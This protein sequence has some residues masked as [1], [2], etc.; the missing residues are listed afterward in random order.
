L[1]L[2]VPLLLHWLLLHR[3]L[4]HSALRRWRTTHGLLLHRRRRLVESETGL[5][6]PS[7]STGNTSMLWMGRVTDTSNQVRA[8]NLTVKVVKDLTLLQLVLYQRSRE[9]SGLH[10]MIVDLW[11]ELGRLN[12]HFANACATLLIEPSRQ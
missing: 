8:I 1:L 11:E 6:L 5:M 2:K 3:L 10:T 4:L 9:A 12:V 7:P